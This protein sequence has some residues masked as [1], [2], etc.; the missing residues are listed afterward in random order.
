MLHHRATASA[1]TSTLRT[2]ISDGAAMP[3][4][5]MRGFKQTFRCTLLEAYGLSETSPVASF[6]HTPTGYAS[7][8][9]A[10]RR[11]IPHRHRCG[12]ATTPA[13]VSATGQLSCRPMAPD[14]ICRG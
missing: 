8:R 4:E 14:A 12:G 7:P 10:G 3:L 5:I 1:D 13:D 9:C 2:C 6:N 11:Q